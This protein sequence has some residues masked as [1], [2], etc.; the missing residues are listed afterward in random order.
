MHVSE[1]L[2]KFAKISHQTS[3]ISHRHDLNYLLNKRKYGIYASAAVQVSFGISLLA[4]VAMEAI[5]RQK[6]K[7]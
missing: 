1:C 5:I 6:K 3:L 4:T 2:Q 7:I